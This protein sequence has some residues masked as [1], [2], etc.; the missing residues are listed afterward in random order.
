MAAPGTQHGGLASTIYATGTSIATALAG[1]HA[2][3]LFDS[4]DG[5]R[6]LHGNTMPAGDLDAVLIKAALVHSAR[7][8]NAHA[9]I[10]H[11]QLELG[12]QRDREAV[13]RI[14][15]YGRA[16]PSNV[17]ACD[18]H[19]VT[20][21]SGGHIAEGEAHV[22]RLPLPPS[23]SART[24]QRR[25]TLTLAWLTPI[26]PFHRAYRR[27]ALTLEPIGFSDLLGSRAES[28]MHSS[29]RG[30]VQHEVHEGHNA[31]PYTPGSTLELSVSCRTDAGA[32]DVS[33]PYALIVTL[34]VPETVTL[35]IYEE[36][37]QALQIPIAVRAVRQ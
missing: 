1:H 27:A 19:R 2:G 12:R 4:I 37:R 14:V 33:V 32:L 29:R 21:L 24:D 34:E 9:L 8:G 30:T 31:V 36:V 17:L 18:E 15:G 16:D 25:I 20:A 6:S 22:Y 10:D 5:L 11:M 3:N 28:S 26:N 35:P 7:W 13:S 23:L